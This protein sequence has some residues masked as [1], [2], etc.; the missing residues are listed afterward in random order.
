MRARR[1]PR[2][3]RRRATAAR[4]RSVP[5]TATSRRRSRAA[6]GRAMSNCHDSPRAAR[7]DISASLQNSWPPS[8]T[9]RSMRCRRREPAKGI[10][11]SQKQSSVASGATSYDESSA[12]GLVGL[13]GMH[14]QRRLRDQ[15]DARARLDAHALLQP[16]AGEDA[17]PAAD[18]NH[19]RDR[20]GVEEPA[21]AQRRL[22]VGVR[23]HRAAAA[24]GKHELHP[25]PAPDV[26]RAGGD[27]AIGMI[28][29]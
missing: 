8:A 7:P 12:A 14:L 2:V 11:G 5:D 28:G 1:A 25:G 9:R 16:V 13:S 23:E 6:R 29:E 10:S 24:A 15:Q 22:G 4:A 18:E 27:R 21:H 26:R 17:G 19:L 3:P 20:P